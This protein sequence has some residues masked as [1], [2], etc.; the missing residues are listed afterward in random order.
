[1]RG[2]QGQH[3]II[4]ITVKYCFSLFSLFCGC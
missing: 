4:Y 2:I 3:D 1:M